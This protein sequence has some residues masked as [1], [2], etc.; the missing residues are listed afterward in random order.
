MFALSMTIDNT[1][2]EQD[3]YSGSMQAYHLY[4]KCAAVYAIDRERRV[5]S[6]LLCYFVDFFYCDHNR[7]LVAR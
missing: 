4:N 1:F 5:S 7:F 2:V 3:Y 6:I